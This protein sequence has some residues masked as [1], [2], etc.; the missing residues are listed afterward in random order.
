MGKIS[1]QIVTP[2]MQLNVVLWEKQGVFF[3]FCNEFALLGTLS[4]ECRVIS[5]MVWLTESAL[6]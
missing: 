4:Y 2:G 5:A 3:D 1:S 6:M